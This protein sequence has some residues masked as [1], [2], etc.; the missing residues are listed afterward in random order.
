VLD[1]KTGQTILSNTL[2]FSRA[3]G[4]NVYPSPCLAGRALFVGN[5]AGETLIVEPTGQGAVIGRN[6]LPRGSGATPAF[7]G[8]RMFIRGGKLLYCIGEP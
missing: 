1:A 5:D 4:A 6:S 3:E 7:S 8:R 2:E